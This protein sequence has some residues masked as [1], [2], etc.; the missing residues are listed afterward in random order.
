MIYYL[1]MKRFTKNV[2]HG[3]SHFCIPSGRDSRQ[4]FCD[5]YK[6]FI[7][8]ALFFIFVCVWRNTLAV[9]FVRDWLA[10]TEFGC[11][12]ICIICELFLLLAFACAV[13]R[14]WQD[15]DIRIPKDDSFQE[16]IKR[17]RFWQVL[18]SEE[19]SPEKNQYGQAPADNPVPLIGEEDLKEAVRKKL[20]VD[21][22]ELK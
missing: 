14:R 15:L 11:W 12:V 6:G 18:A 21:V 16:L 19:G 8:L 2:L 20:F 5:I 17:P 13:L 9:V 4:T 22:D 1:Y 10:I 3:L 7:L